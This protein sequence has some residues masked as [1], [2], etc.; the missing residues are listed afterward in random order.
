MDDVPIH[1]DKGLRNA[2][3]L[4]DFLKEFPI[5]PQIHN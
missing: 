5:R 2:H 1:F 4:G 3:N